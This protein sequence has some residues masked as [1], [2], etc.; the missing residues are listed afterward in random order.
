[1]S[2]VSRTPSWKFV[3]AEWPND[4][5][6]CLPCPFILNDDHLTNFS[7]YTRQC[8]KRQKLSEVPGRSREP[9][10]RPPCTIRISRRQEAS[11][12]RTRKGGAPLADILPPPPPVRRSSNHSESGKRADK[13]GRSRA[14]TF[15]GIFSLADDGTF[16]IPDAKAEPT[17]CYGYRPSAQKSFVRSHGAYLARMG[18]KQHEWMNDIYWDAEGLYSGKR[19]R[20]RLRACP[21]GYEK[22]RSYSESRTVKTQTEDGKKARERSKSESSASD[23]LD[24]AFREAFKILDPDPSS[25]S[26]PSSPRPKRRTVSSLSLPTLF[27][28]EDKSSDTESTAN[29]GNGLDK[30]FLRKSRSWNSLPSLSQSTSWRDNSDATSSSSL[31]RLPGK[32]SLESPRSPPD[33]DDEAI[34]I[35]ERPAKKQRLDGATSTDTWSSIQGPGFEDSQSLIDS[36]THI[37]PLTGEVDF[38]LPPGVE[39][40]TRALDRGEGHTQRTLSSSTR[41]ESDSSPTP[42]SFQP[43]STIV[44]KAYD[45]QASPGRESDSSASTGLSSINSSFLEK[46]ART[47]GIEAVEHLFGVTT[48][49]KSTLLTATATL[50]HKMSAFL[51]WLQDSGT[52]MAHDPADRAIL[53]ADG[54]F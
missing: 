54:I 34:D 14:A 1:M 36:L 21:D 53:V 39:M 43:M 46:L 25:L 22:L 35:P 6:A 29:D 50:K 40:T 11:P 3:F 38:L 41:P 31:D 16:P 42:G 10:S 51:T 24:A 47:A 4:E 5:P 7:G 8:K 52:F 20:T 32:S 13:N 33:E 44:Q 9:A 27:P 45:R 2:T 15:P 37:N 49:V 30:S 28:G 48:P 23:E 12:S 19:A 17:W 26:P 18:S